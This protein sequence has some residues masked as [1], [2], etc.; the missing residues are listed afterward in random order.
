MILFQI[1]N[2]FGMRVTT[3]SHFC[4]EWVTSPLISEGLTKETTVRVSWFYEYCTEVESRQEGL[5]A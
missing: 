5:G 3:C 2:L 4:P 1:R